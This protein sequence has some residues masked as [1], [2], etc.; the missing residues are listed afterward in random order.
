MT[1]HTHLTAAL[2]VVVIVFF[3]ITMPITSIGTQIIY[4][5]RICMV[6]TEHEVL[7]SVE[8]Y[9]SVYHCPVLMWLNCW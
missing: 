6:L 4:Y 5:W 7:F 8:D 9:A 3:S 1:A 2:T